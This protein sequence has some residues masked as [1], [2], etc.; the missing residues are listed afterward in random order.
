MGPFVYHNLRGSS[1]YLSHI[2][3]IEVMVALEGR[4][5]LVSGDSHHPLVV[6]PFPNLPR[7]R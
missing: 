1:N 3:F 5:G 2:L 7:D 4:K 6:P